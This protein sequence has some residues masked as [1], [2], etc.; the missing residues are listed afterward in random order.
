MST[1]F[2][3]LRK[4]A[5]KICVAVA[6]AGNVEKPMR[7]AKAMLMK[8]LDFNNSMI[9]MD[10][11]VHLDEL[12]ACGQSCVDRTMILKLDICSPHQQTLEVDDELAT[13]S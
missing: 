11:T 9:V 7:N 3:H 6:Y 8:R 13:V 10:L 1:D 2:L 5:Q 4:L 12:L